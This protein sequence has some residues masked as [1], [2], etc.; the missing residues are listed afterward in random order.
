MKIKGEL[1]LII[2]EYYINF[3]YF[4]YMKLTILTNL[5]IVDI[6]LSNINSFSL[7]LILY[8]AII[9]IVSNLKEISKK[10]KNYFITYSNMFKMI[11]TSNIIV[12]N[13]FNFISSIIL[14]LVQKLLIIF[15]NYLN[16]IKIFLFLN[17]VFILI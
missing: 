11:L 6:M 5:V 14:L 9:I 7:L 15:L 13:F 17:M 8:Y 12:A 2:F 4:S 3:V 1:Y 10:Y 16:I